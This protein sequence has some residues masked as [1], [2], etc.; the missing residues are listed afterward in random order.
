MSGLHGCSENRA[1][2][3]AGIKVRIVKDDLTWAG[4]GNTP[5]KATGASNKKKRRKKKIGICE[6][7]TVCGS[8][9]E[10][11]KHANREKSSQDNQGQLLLGESKKRKTMNWTKQESFR[12]II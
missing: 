12:T 5:A 9:E 1:D 11:D 4:A 10:M 8:N 7:A 6:M 2:K 3:R